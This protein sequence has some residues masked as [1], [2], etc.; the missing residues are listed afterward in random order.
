MATVNS[1]RILGKDWSVGWV[2][3]TLGDSCGECRKQSLELLVST[4][5]SPDQQRDT[6]LHEVIH[7]IDYT[8]KLNM[9]E[10]QVHALAGLLLAVFRDNPEFA[11]YLSG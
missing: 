2:D 11:E 9:S 1:L 5:A 3:K 6:L 10:D 8:A 7:A 4:E